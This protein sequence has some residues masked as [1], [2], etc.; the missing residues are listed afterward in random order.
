MDYLVSEISVKSQVRQYILFS[1][2]CKA[3][4]E[5]KIPFGNKRKPTIVVAIPL[6]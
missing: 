1:I 3:M 2:Y 4:S 6:N 5:S